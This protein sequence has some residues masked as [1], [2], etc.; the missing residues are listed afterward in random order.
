MNKWINKSIKLA[1]SKGYLDKLMEVYPVNLTLVRNVSAVEKNKIKK[2]FSKKNNKELIS[3]LLGLERFPIDDPYIGF[4]RKD[5]N[6]LMKN[7]KT[8]RRIGNR[9]L[10][11]GLKEIIIGASRAKAPSRQVGQMFRKWLYGLRYPVLNEVDFLKNRKVAILQGGDA[12][13][14]SFAKKRLSYK[15]KKGLDMVLRIGDKFILGEAKFITTSGGTQ[16]KSFREG[17]AFIKQKNKNINCIAIMDGVVWLVSQK[18]K[19]NKKLSLYN[20]IINLGDN[21]IVL[22]ALLLR[23]FIK[24]EN[25]K[26]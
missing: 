22:S 11:I 21:K 15:G 26:I 12:A 25:N 20:T 1:N 24:E 19:K 16:D 14:V 8:I 23:D 10:K 13:L 2:A 4:L 18:K 5:K 7:P 9:L 17:T 6:A 3:V